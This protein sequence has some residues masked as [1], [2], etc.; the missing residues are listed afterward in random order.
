MSVLFNAKLPTQQ[1]I[2]SY[3]QTP[4]LWLLIIPVPI[5]SIPVIHICSPVASIFIVPLHLPMETCCLHLSHRLHLYPPISPY[6]PVPSP[7]S[8]SSFC[9]HPSRPIAFM[10]LVLSPPSISSHSSLQSRPIAFITLVLSPPSLSSRHS[11]LPSRPIAFISLVPPPPFYCPVAPYHLVP[12][13]PSLSLS[14]HCRHAARPITPIPVVTL[15]I[16]CPSHCPYSLFLPTPAFVPEAQTHK[17]LLL[18][19][20]S[21]S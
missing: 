19:Q 11:S 1:C 13:P 10:S 7:P 6:R 4:Y 15:S 12:S 17:R 21:F 16:F 14:S 8:L 3:E 18:P 20:V 2:V 9:T 5:I